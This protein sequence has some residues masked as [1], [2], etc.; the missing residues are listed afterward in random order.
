[1]TEDFDWFGHTGL[2]DAHIRGES[3]ATLRDEAGNFI[4]L[5]SGCGV[6]DMDASVGLSEIASLTIALNNLLNKT[7]DPI[8]QI[9][10]QKRS[11]DV[12]VTWKV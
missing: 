5:A 2:I 3:V 4:R 6:I 11:V 7:H 8:D 12:F 1:M 10:G 9:H